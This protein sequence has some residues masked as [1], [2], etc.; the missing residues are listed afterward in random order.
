[1][2]Q[3]FASK[4][5]VLKLF[6]FTA[7]LW[8]LVCA[9]VSAQYGGPLGGG[10][11]PVPW[12]HK[13]KQ[14]KSDPN[15]PTISADG[16]TVSNDGKTLVVDIPDG[17]TLTIKLTPETKFTR[18]GSS[19]EA[20]SVVP[21][22]VVHVEAAEDQESYLTAIRVELLKDAAQTASA[23]PQTRT[24]A[25]SRGDQAGTARPAISNDPVD[26]PDRPIL[27]RGVPKRTSSDE[28]D[29]GN[30]EVSKA[31][32]RDTARASASPEPSHK[33]TTDFTISDDSHSAKPAASASEGLI[34]RTKE[35]SE[36][37]T[38]GLPNFVCQQSTTRYMQES[39]SSG[40]QVQDVVTAKVVYEDGKENYREITVGGKRTNKS[41]LDV[42]GSTS[43]GEFA[44]TLYSLFSGASQAQFRFFR[45]TTLRDSPTAIY[46]FNVALPN[47]NWMT[48]T[49]GQA[50]R[51]AYSG[52]VWIDRTTAQVR[53]I[54]MQADN[55][56]K[57]F[58][59]D[60][61]QWAVDYENVPLG[62]ASFLLP[63]H[64]ENLACWRGSPMCTKNQV[65][66]RDYHKYSGE[67]TITFDK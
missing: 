25:V 57:D 56:P 52:S 20:T 30:T 48:K 33:E 11:I 44:S 53:R 60:S 54:E 65:D 38:N 29:T 49:G 8:V 13:K 14:Q 7:L 47:S 9:P 32:S 41:M 51:P 17:R 55:I 1:M 66:F 16:K 46:D 59:L 63:V 27:R 2:P 21:R 35:W 19:V 24:V 15:A 45:S 28:N 50:L 67:S 42:G 34:K 23:E 36:T 43:T 58:P 64:A 40:W 18:S 61:L 6:V 62:T 3:G 26:V 39:E 37:F 10:G 22:T 5:S 12:G 4:A 31:E